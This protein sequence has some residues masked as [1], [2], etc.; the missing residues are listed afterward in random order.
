MKVGGII[1][2]SWWWVTSPLWIAA[3]INIFSVIGI[4]LMLIILKRLLTKFQKDINN[5]NTTT[6]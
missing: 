5:K 3:I 1:D 4:Y 6:K 2:W